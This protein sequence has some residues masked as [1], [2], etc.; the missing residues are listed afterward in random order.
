MKN[1]EL[2]TALYDAE[3]KPDIFAIQEAKP[4]IAK[5]PWNQLWLEVDDY[6]LEEGAWAQ[7]TQVEGCLF[8]RSKPD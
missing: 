1:M 7:T 3:H 8:Q 2:K 4:K 6:S 5:V